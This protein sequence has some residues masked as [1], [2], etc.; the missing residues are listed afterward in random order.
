MVK[1]WTVVDTIKGYHLAQ[2]MFKHCIVV[3]TVTG[4]LFGSECGQ[5]VDRCE[6]NKGSI[7][8]LKILSNI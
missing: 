4:V 7:V 6:H 3:N 8:F 5:V 2:N 1:Q